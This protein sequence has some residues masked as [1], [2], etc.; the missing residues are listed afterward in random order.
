M[1]F[2]IVLRSAAELCGASNFSANRR[3]RC[4]HRARGMLTCSGSGVERDFQRRSP[5]ET[6]RGPGWALTGQALGVVDKRK[7]QGRSKRSVEKV[8]EPTAVLPRV[9]AEVDSPPIDPGHA[10][11]PRHEIDDWIVRGVASV[12]GA[13][14]GGHCPY[15]PD[16]AHRGRPIRS[17]IQLPRGSAPRWPRVSTATVC[18]LI[19]PVTVDVARQHPLCAAN[20]LSTRPNQ[21][22]STPRR[23]F[24]TPFILC[25]S[26]PTVLLRWIRA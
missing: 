1:S 26:N 21:S 22:G 18:P 7:C 19:P 10:P 2:G 25:L 20:P 16:L 14:V 24:P 5:A 4:V 3:R 11:C 15:L 6:V 12:R 13:G 8:A 9:R 23:S 17:T